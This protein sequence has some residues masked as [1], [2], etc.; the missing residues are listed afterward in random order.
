MGWTNPC[1]HLVAFEILLGV[2]KTFRKRQTPRLYIAFY[3]FW[4][5]L[6]GTVQNCNIFQPL[7]VPVER[8]S[9]FLRPAFQNIL[10]GLIGHVVHQIV[11][12]LCFIQMI[13]SPALRHLAVHDGEVSGSGL[14][15]SAFFK[16]KNLLPHLRR[17]PDGRHSGQTAAYH[18][19]IRG[20]CFGYGFFPDLWLFSQ[21]RFPSILIQGCSLRFFFLI[22]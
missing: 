7:Q 16:E 20:H 22:I 3:A 8:L 12:N 2:V 17:L 6:I 4:R 19:D 10:T 1:S 9:S 18:N 21:P 5:G 14:N 13:P 15:T 11:D